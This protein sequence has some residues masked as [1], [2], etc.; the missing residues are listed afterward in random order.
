MWSPSLWSIRKMKDAQEELLKE[1]DEYTDN[2][3]EQ[4]YRHNDIQEIAADG[5]SLNQV[6]N[7][8]D[9]INCVL[10]QILKNAISHI[11]EFLVSLGKKKMLQK[12]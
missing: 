10:D 4:K 2:L 8:C 9:N 11:H 3:A 6:V 12:F 7:L 1:E 5:I